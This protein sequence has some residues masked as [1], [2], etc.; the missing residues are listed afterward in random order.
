MDLKIQP[1]WDCLWKWVREIPWLKNLSWKKRCHNERKKTRLVNALQRV[2]NCMCS[3]FQISGMF[4]VIW[5]LSLLCYLFSTFISIPE[6]AS[7]LCLVGF[8]F[9]Y[10]INPVRILHYKARMWLLRILVR[11]DANLFEND[12]AVCFRHRVD[13]QGHLQPTTSD[14]CLSEEAEYLEIQNLYLKN[15]D[16]PNHPSVYTLG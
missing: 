13:S 10:L 9:L 8:C 6:F 1:I 14:L 2:T 3:I 16:N 5:A 11:T 15:S 4:S 7:P 12:T